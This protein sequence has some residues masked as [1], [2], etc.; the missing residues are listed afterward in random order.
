MTESVWVLYNTKL[1][2]FRELTEAEAE[3]ARKFYKIVHRVWDDFY[4][5]FGDTWHN[6]R[7]DMF[8]W[9]REKGYETN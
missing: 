2:T 7:N 9:R 4:N 5:K 8:M 3:E 1:Q 6:A